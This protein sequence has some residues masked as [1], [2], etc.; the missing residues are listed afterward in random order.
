MQ[1]LQIK[2][3]NGELV[4]FAPAKILTRIKKA[5]K[6]LQI[7]SEHLFI[8]V[9][10]SMPTEGIVT[11]TELDT[12]IANT[13]APYTGTHY[14]YSY[15]AAHVA[16]SSIHKE[17]DLDFYNMIKGL[18][19]SGIV[20][21]KLVD[22]VEGYGRDNV[23]AILDFD[24]NNTF[25][26][27]AWKTLETM[28]LLKDH[29][30]KVVE[31][32]QH[33]YLRVALWATRS[34]EE[35][36][37][38]YDKLSMQ[39]ISCATPIMI[40]AG[41]KNSQLA[42][43][44]LHYNESDSRE[45][46][47]ST[48]SDISTYS[49]AGAGIG[50]SMSNIRSKE[51]RIKSSGGYAG[52]LLK[53]LKIVNESLRFFNQQGRR[54][55]SAAIY[56]EPWH[57]DIIDLLDIKKNTG[58][59]ELRAKDLFTAIMIP[60]NFMRAIKENGDWY[61]FCPN[62]IK[63]A[64]LKAFNKIHGDE[65]EAEYAKAIELGIGKKVD[66]KEILIK[67]IESQIET[68]VPYILFK[69]H[70][71][72]KSNH[73]NYGTINQSNL[74]AEIV[75]YTDEWTTAICTLASMVLK[76][77]I[78]GKEFDFDLLGESVEQTVDLLNKVIDINSYVTEKGKKGGLQQRAMAIG[79]QGLA[80]TFFL[81][82]YHFTSPE[83]KQLNKDIFETIYY[84]AIKKSCDLVES[85]LYTP[86]DGF[87]GSPMSKGIFQFNMWGIDEEQLSGRYEWSKLGERVAKIGICNSLF[88]A[89][90]PVASSA[91]ITD[92]FEMTE[93]P[94]SNLFNRRVIGGEFL[95]AN[96][97]LV[98]DLEKI[99]LWN[100]TLKN[101]L[102]MEGGSVQN[103]N[104]QKYLDVEDKNYAK[105]V[106]RVEYLIDKYRTVW[107]YK[108][109]DLIDLAADRAVFI[110]QTQSMNIYMSAP[111][112]SKLTSSMFYSWEKGL[113][114][115]SYYVRTKSISTGAKH[116]AVDISKQVEVVTKPEE[117]TTSKPASSPFECFGCSA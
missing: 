21:Q 48:L 97:Y 112:P 39:L 106:K 104:F 107:E 98:D 37:A 40:N 91:N 66:V 95:I 96:K 24:R 90:M 18:A 27:F 23:Q 70:I 19:D 86:Y 3:R 35:A 108:Q 59:E 63:K 76:N 26:F 115:G 1:M 94:N 78:K 9:I 22:I 73:Q 101:E 84:H 68:G 12:L 47:L 117:P 85:G 7:N 5:A 10:T 8:N 51:S 69:D 114:T 87:H 83:A 2:K 50:I 93:A 11:T 38:L 60:D 20:N 6:G 72:R 34:L 109:K 64:G 74:C 57:K 67:L 45:G 43:C 113:K 111:T 33:M 65:Y 54:P 100:E 82:D 49:S 15:F 92:S 41:T 88:T 81:M 53:Y 61:T 77:Y 36:K 89:Q 99:G 25:N 103:I 31:S 4:A 13:A 32:P 52:G 55:G 102:I 16:I 28:Y 80:D 29:N 17:I 56:L 71:N 79:V 30:G 46:L 75:Q 116:L 105:K 62:D 110:D 58:A 14:D 44:V 42:S